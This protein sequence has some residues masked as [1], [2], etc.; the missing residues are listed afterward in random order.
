M[1]HKQWP[2]SYFLMYHQGVVDDVLTEGQILASALQ[3]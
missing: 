1:N 3:C 2:N